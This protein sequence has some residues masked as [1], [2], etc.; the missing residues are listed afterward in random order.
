MKNAPCKQNGQ[1]CPDRQVGCH[2]KC[3]KYREWKEM[4]EKAN[5]NRYAYKETDINVWGGRKRK[6]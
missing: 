4:V 6:K 2:S 1:D 5:A 3:E